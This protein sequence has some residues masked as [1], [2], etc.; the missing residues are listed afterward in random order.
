MMLWALLLVLFV[1]LLIPILAI[2]LDS[3]V[4]RN[5]SHSSESV[6]L[7]EVMDRVRALED[8]VHAMGREI[9]SLQ[10]ETQF[11]QRLLDNPDRQEH[12][13]Q[14]SPPES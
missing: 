4:A 12:P 10:E 7:G 9:E 6:R 3:P 11:V 2:V 1:A 8:E 14:I 5:L 13:K